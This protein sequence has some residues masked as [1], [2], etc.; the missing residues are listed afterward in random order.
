MEQTLVVPDLLTR[1]EAQGQRLQD[2]Q[3]IGQGL[4]PQS[5]GPGADRSLWSC[6]EGQGGEQLGDVDPQCEVGGSDLTASHGQQVDQPIVR[7]KQV[8]AGQTAV[9]DARASQGGQ[10]VPRVQE[11]RVGDLVLL[12]LGQGVSVDVLEREKCGIGPDL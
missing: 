4:G 2:R 10:L 8:V 12:H 1:R 11:H 6:D 9:R 3:R 5:F 7:D